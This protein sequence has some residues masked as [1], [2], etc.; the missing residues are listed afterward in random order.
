MPD[1]N[2]KQRSSGARFYAI[3]FDLAAAVLGFSLVGYWIDRHYGSSPWGL[4]VCAV[5]GVIGGLYN[6]IRDS[7]KAF[8]DTVPR[9]SR[10]R[11]TPKGD[12]DTEE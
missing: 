12:G 1:S 5:L 2:T 8:A 7:R 4:L 9:T 10:T 6:L 11:R 3:G